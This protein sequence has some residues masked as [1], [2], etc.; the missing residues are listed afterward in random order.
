MELALKQAWKYQ[1]LTYPN[2][3]VGAVVVN[4]GKILSIAAHQ[5]AGGPHAEVYAIKEAYE[6]LT[7]QKIDLQNS[8]DIHRFLL[9]HHDNLFKNCTIYTTLEP[10]NHVGKTPSCANLIQKLGFKRVVVGMRDANEIAKEGAKRFGNVTF[11]VLEKKCQELLEP[12]VIWQKRAFV[13]FKLAQSH[14]GNI[15]GGY[16]SSKQSLTHVHQIREKITALLIGG[17]TVKTDKPTLDCRFTG[18]KAPNVQIY[19]NQTFDKTINLF[20]VAGRTVTISK[21]LSF[22]QKPGFVLVEGGENMLKSMQNK[23]DWM[24]TFQAP[25]ISNKSGYNANIDL[26]YLHIDRNSSDIIIWSKVKNG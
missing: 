7:A 19:S 13:L 6:N 16:I 14:N 17:N 12:F 20:S 18:K 21:D 23:I 8:A 3:A 2:P 24:L 25:S 1:G 9:Q 11:G 4:E 10:C 26:E 22:L 5:F 15:T